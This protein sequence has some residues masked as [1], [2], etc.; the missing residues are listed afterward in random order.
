MPSSLAARVHQFHEGHYLRQHNDRAR[1]RRVAYILYLAPGWKSKFGGV[2]A[3]AG[4]DRHITRIVPRY[5]SLLLFD[6]YSQKE[7]QIEPV[8]AAAKGKP[9][10][11][12][13]AWLNSEPKTKIQSRQ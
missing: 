10:L 11:T 6:V 3:I 8:L 1:D 2:L 4:K 7:H 9:R 12:M 5:N 13:S